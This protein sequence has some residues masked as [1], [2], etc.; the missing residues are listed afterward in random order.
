MKKWFQTLGMAAAGG[1]TAAAAQY[2]TAAQSPSFDQLGA[3]AVTGAT[4]NALA[5]LLRSPWLQQAQQTQAQA[6]QQ[7]K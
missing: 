1:A 4:M 5:Y 7:G 3:A 6:G 2:F